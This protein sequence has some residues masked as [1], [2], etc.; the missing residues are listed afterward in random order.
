MAKWEQ[1]GFKCEGGESGERDNEQVVV[2]G[3]YTSTRR[4]GQDRCTK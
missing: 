4:M 1:R 2:V 3:G